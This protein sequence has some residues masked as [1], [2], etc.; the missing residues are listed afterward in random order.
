MKRAILMGG[1]VTT[2]LGA[3]AY[4]QDYGPKAGG[5]TAAAGQPT[6]ITQVVVTGTRDPATTTITSPSPIDV[7]TAQRMANTGFTDLA[8]GLE[9]IEPEI[10]ISRSTSQ[11][12]FSSTRALTLDGLYPDELLL[13]VN[14]IRYHASSVLG[15]NT[16]LGRGSVPYDL[17]TIP[18]DAIDRIEVLDDGA[19]AQYGSDAI[20]GV[21]NIILKSNSSGGNIIGQGGVTAHGDGANG[22]ISMNRGFSIGGAGFISV[23]LEGSVQEATDRAAIDQLYGRHTFWLGDPYSRGVNLALNGAYPGLPFGEVYGDFLVSYR[24]STDKVT[25]IAPGVSPLYPNGFLPESTYDLFDTQASLGVRGSFVGGFKYNLSNSFGLSNAP[26]NADDTTNLTLGPSGPTS[27]FD[28]E[29]TYWQDVTD[30]TFTRPL[31]DV[32][33]GG[34][35]ALGG[36]VRYEHY[37]I[38]NGSLASYYPGGGADGL[39]GLHTRIPVD[40]DRTA[41]AAFADFSLHPTSWTTIDAAGRYDHYSDFGGALTYKVSGRIAPTSWLAFRGSIGTGFRAPSLEQTYY[42]AITTSGSGPLN[43]LVPAGIFQVSDPVAVAL[44]ARPLKPESSH[45]YSVGAVFTPTSRLTI[46]AGVFRIDIANR[47]TLTDSQNAIANGTP[48]QQDVYKTLMAAGATNVSAVSFFANGAKTQTDG[49]TLNLAYRG[50]LGEAT[51]YRVTVAY[52]RNFTKLS[53]LATYSFLPTV[54]LLGTHSQ[55]LL[56]EAQPADKWTGNFTLYHGRATA[57]LDFTRYG[58]YTDM[59]FTPI[60][61]F[62]PQIIV[63]I[64]LSYEILPKTTATVGVLNLFNSYPPEVQG[65]PFSTYGGAYKY[66]PNNPGGSDGLTSFVRLT[67]QF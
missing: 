53:S 52:D 36:Q 29:P 30:A 25:F 59:P 62:G 13:L 18:L 45:N 58:S 16:G 37:D 64:S 12:S 6:D 40:N 51:R 66:D 9:T 57:T 22:D 61:T 50:E 54:P 35:L 48:I 47:V 3:N 38:T 34:V 10:N 21:V 31:P 39:V 24:Q 1:V 55:M 7:F 15:T 4:A 32:L 44:G 8:R 49:A 56:T 67:R 42:N 65:Q 63:D 26:F 46:T 20:A 27:F 17:N 41:V 11:P 14:G 60:Q 33:A 23:S 28:G 43:T 19:A 2:L 5:A